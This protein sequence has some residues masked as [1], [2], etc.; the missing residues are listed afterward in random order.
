MVVVLVPVP[1]AEHCFLWEAVHY[2]A[3]GRL[4][5]NRHPITGWEEREDFEWQEAN[6][7]YYPGGQPGGFWDPAYHPSGTAVSDE[8]FK[9][10][11]I[12]RP[13][14]EDSTTLQRREAEW[15]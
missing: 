9:S 7:H 3:F 15:S 8:T 6:S 5:L 13:Q 2:A 12:S 14:M 4:P 1:I 10:V 11:G